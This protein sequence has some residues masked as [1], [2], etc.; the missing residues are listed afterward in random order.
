MAK[1]SVFI[2]HI[3]GDETVANTLEAIIR[4]ALLGGVEIF[5]ASNRKSLEAGDPWRDKI[6][7]SLRDSASV[8]VLASPDSVASPWVNFEAGGAWIAGTRVIPCCIKGMNPASLPAPLSH[9]QALN[10]SDPD[11]LRLLIKQLADLAGLDFPAD[12]DYQ[13]SA[14]TLS[15]SFDSTTSSSE[16][17]DFREWF[18]RCERRPA[19]YCGQSASGHFRIE[20][21]KATHPQQTEQFPQEGLKPG[22]SLTCWLTVDGEQSTSSFH[23]FARGNVADTLES[24]AEKTLL[25]GEVKCLGQI[26]VYESDFVMFD[27]DRGVSYP[28]AWL[29]VRAQE[30]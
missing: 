1:A 30:A 11:H 24:A 27:E 18:A 19:K 15:D 9:L 3:H 10:A 7:A 8:L 17:A 26:K 12:H 23:C 14:R 21:L 13:T 4:K 29:I 16:N 2:S 28:T 20:H 5:N 6:I 25:Q 22:D